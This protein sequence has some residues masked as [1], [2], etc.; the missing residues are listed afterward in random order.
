MKKYENHPII[1]K[2]E[3]MMGKENL[4]FPFKFID[5]KKI[6]NELENLKNRKPC[7]ESDILVNINTIT[8]FIYKIVLLIV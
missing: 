5:K 3:K 8:Y 7:E 6:F 4:S 1:L 2:A